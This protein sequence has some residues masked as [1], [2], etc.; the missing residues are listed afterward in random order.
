M[1]LIDTARKYI[2]LQEGSGASDNATILG[3]ANELGL[4]YTSDSIAW[5]ALFMSWVAYEGGYEGLKTLRARD[6][7]NV[8]TPVTEPQKGDV[9]IFWRG[10]PGGS[11]GHVGIYDGGTADDVITL[12]GN[13]DDK[14]GIGYYPKGRVLGYRRLTKIS[15]VNGSKNLLNPFLVIVGIPIVVTILYKL[16][17]WIYQE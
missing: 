3:W 2:G 4:P 15:G 10:S 11:L 17:T 8:G 5:C 12:G 13:Q 6:W 7:L 1:T 16:W 14:V 9:V